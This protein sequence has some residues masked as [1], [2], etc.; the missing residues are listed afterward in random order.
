MPIADS[1]SR[2]LVCVETIR[3]LP[4][5]RVPVKVRD[6]RD[7]DGALRKRPSAGEDDVFL[8]VAGGLEGWAAHTLRLLNKGIEG[9][10]FLDHTGYF[11][12]HGTGT[13]VGDP[14]ELKNLVSPVR[15]SGALT[16]LLRHTPGGN[17]RRRRVTTTAWSALVEIGPHKALK[18]P[19]R[20]IMSAWDGTSPERIPYMSLLSR[21][22]H[23]RE[24]ALTAAG[25]FWANGH[26][27][28][29]LEQ[30]GNDDRIEE[31]FG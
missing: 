14:I 15:F 24:T 17:P 21:G 26:P 11:E 18:G 22:K 12:A 8:D 4:V 30:T 23:A 25:M 31:S 6:A 2:P 5:C 28:D 27:I 29:L 3:V 9:R 20:Q 19:C 13:S 1:L 7:E 16:T 10:H